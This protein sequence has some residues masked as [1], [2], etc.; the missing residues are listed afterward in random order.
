M[1]ETPKTPKTPETVTMV[2]LVEFTSTA[3]LVVMLALGIAAG[4]VA[5]YLLTHVMVEDANDARNH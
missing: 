2:E 5:Y 1:P 4:L 3:K